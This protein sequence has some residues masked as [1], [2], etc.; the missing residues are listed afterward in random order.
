[1]TLD[2][3]DVEAIAARVV[4]LQHEHRVERTGWVTAK[5]VAEHLGVSLDCV[6]AHA[7]AW[8]AARI[9]GGSTPRMRFR[10]DL[11]D[12][13]VTCFAGRGPTATQTVAA[14]G[15]SGGGR[16][17]SAGAEPDLPPIRGSRRGRRPR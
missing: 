9:G 15:I 5:V 8:G 7:Q 14:T 13:A 3:E 10:L 2:R 16:G 6:Y 11:V 1:V 4:E 12:K 17:G